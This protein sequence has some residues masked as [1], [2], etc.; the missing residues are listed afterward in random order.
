VD[1]R[2]VG[3]GNVGAT[4]AS[5]VLGRKWFLVVFALDFAKG[6][7]PVFL[8]AELPG[9]T[10]APLLRFR[11]ACGL[12]AIAG[13]VFPVFLGFRGG[14][15]VATGAGVLTALVPW[16]ALASFGAF[17]TSLKLSRYVSLSSVIA[18]AVLAPISWLLGAPGEL[19]V[20]CALVGG[21]VI[22]LHRKNLARIASGTEPKCFQRKETCGA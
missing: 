1:V 11:M 8:F 17:L 7:L 4:N 12:A 22:L 14:K 9:Y 18:C 2:T 10:D 6:A 13:H 21:L 3:S 20:F 19:I 16:A 15:G 5:R